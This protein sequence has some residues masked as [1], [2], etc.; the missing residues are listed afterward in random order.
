MKE[1]QI[2]TYRKLLGLRLLR[3]NTDTTESHKKTT[4]HVKL[5]ASKLEE[6]LVYREQ[7]LVCVWT[8]R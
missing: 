6:V 5:N 8:Q 3:M 7:D 2:M 4:Q 1:K